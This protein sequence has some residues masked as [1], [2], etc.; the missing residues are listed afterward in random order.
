MQGL[1][2]TWLGHSSFRVRTPGGK[3]ILFDP[4]YTGNPAFPEAARPTK[5]TGAT[6][7][8]IWE[9]CSYLG[10]KGVKNLE[11]MNKGGTITVQGLRITMTDARHSSSFN[12]HGVHNLGEAA[13]FV[14]KL[15]NGQTIYY[16]GDT[17]L[18]GDMKIIAELYQPDIAFLPIGDRFT[19]GPDTAAIAAKWLGVKQVVPM[20]YGTFP[21][22]TGTPEQ[23]E[24]HLSG[25]G[26]EVLKLKR[27][28]TA[29]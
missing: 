21:L 1:A 26:I 7:V 9:I 27:G 19:M 23:L 18:F 17:C 2:I 8:G 20:H 3:E 6:V 29:E 12:D 25:S 4:W 16:A 10:T 11:P 5:A 14:V 24:Q 15:E 22:L 13:G 28:E